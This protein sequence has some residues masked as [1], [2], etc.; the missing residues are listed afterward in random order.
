MWTPGIYGASGGQVQPG[1][2]LQACQSP[3][4]R[5]FKPHPKKPGLAEV[6]GS[7]RLFLRLSCIDNRMFAR[8]IPVSCE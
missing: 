2:I 8:Y 5:D 7:L 4:R 3:E 1:A 6:M